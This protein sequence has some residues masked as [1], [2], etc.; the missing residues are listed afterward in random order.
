MSGQNSSVI[1]VITNKESWGNSSFYRNR[2]AKTECDLL[3]WLGFWQKT[4]VGKKRK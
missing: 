1:K 2:D 4:L 3:Y